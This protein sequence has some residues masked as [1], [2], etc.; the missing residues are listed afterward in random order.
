M[1]N[2]MNLNPDF[3]ENVFYD[4]PDYPVYIRKGRL[5]DYPHY[6]AQ[7]HWHD[8][9]EMIRILSGCMRYNI[10]GEI[11]DLREG[12]G[13]LVN[14]RQLHFGYSDDNSECIFICILLHPIL[15]CSSRGIERKYVVPLLTDEQIPYYHLKNS[16][17]W[18]KHILEDM[19]KIYNIQNEQFSEL[20]IQRELYDIWIVLCEH[21]LSLQKEPD[22]H[23]H[24]LSS[25]RNMISYIVGNYRD[26]ISLE[27]IAKAGNVGKTGCCF[28]FKKYTNRTPNEYT[29]QFRL[30]KSVDLLMQTNLS[31]LEITYEVGFSGASYFTET[32]RKCYGCTPSEYRK[33]K[34]R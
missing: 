22:Y 31:V 34:K 24:H 28:I 1:E 16:S 8:D 19:R 25:L 9:I 15:L 2:H 4:R 27:N 32:F 12:E 10:N 33:M 7:S 26:K 30:R 11:V 29:T 21:I 6:T 20:K 23:N 3:S 5:S 13:I 18:E 14:T 17:V